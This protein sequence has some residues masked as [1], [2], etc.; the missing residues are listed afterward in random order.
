MWSVLE[1]NAF[2]GEQECGIG[3][4]AE[5]WNRA[6]VDF[7]AGDAASSKKEA[8]NETRVYDVDLKLIFIT[9]NS[10]LH[11]IDKQWRKKNILLCGQMQL[12]IWK[13]VLYEG[14]KSGQA[15]LFWNE[16]IGF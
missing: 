9:W 2:G 13:S 11:K 14:N 5:T 3:D 15:F 1:N 7:L 4:I 8:V 6:E 12:Y 16:Y 10:F